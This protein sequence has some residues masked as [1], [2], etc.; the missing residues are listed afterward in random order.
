MA[1][2][3]V[4]VESPAKA[5]TIAGFLGRDYVV[6]ASIGHIR[7]LPTGAAEVPDAYKGEPWARIGVDVDNDFKPLYIIP[8]QKKEQVRKLKGLVKDASEVYLATDEDREGESIA[9]HLSEVLAPR[10][11]VKRMVFHEITRPAIDRA[12]REWRDLD[13]RLVDAQE[14][15]RI[16]DRLYGYEVSPVLWKKV[17]PSL[18]AGRVQSVATRLLVERERAR[19]RFRSASFWDVEGVFHKDGNAERF[20]ASLVSVDGR[21]LASGRDF[22]E[23]GRL[24]AGSAGVLVLDEA[25]ASGLADRLA[26][27]RFSVRSVE[28]KPYRRSPYPPFMTSTLQQEAGRKLRFSS[29]RTMRVAQ[30]LY[31]QGYITYM[32]TDSTTLSAEALA[33]ARSQ[34]RSLYG[35]AYVP[36]QPRRYDKKVKNAQEAHE[37][38]RPAGE[39]FRTPDQTGLKGDMFRLYDLVWKR[40]VAS[41]MADAR[42]HSI[43]VR[44]GARSSSGD[45]AEFATSG[46]TIEFPGFLRAYV[47][48][49]DDP[50]AALEDQEVRLPV[51]AVGDALDALAL[52]AKGHAT[53]PPAR[54]TEASL[55]KALE[56]LGVGR[57][58]T[59]ASIIE[60][61]Q[62][63]GYVDRR[64]TA[65][66]PSWT[67]FAVVGLLEQYFTQLVDYGFTAQMEEELDEIA[68]GQGEAIPW[69][70]RFYFGDAAQ[71]K[72][73]HPSQG[74]LKQMVNDQLGEIDAREVNSIPVGNGIVLRVGRYGPYIQR[75]DDRA[76]VPEDLAPDELTVA[77]AE[78]LLDAGS[79]DRPLGDDPDTGLPVVARA[80][81]FGPYVQLGG[82]DAANGGRGAKPK[83]Q[84]LLGGTTLD[85][86]TLD[87]ALR[88]LSLPRVVGA[89]VDGEEILAA[90]GRFG[91]YLKKGNDSRRLDSDDQLF[92]VTLD[93]ARALFA[94]PRPD[95]MAR[96]AAPLRELGPDPVSGQLVTVKE[97][98]FGPYV[99]DGITNASLRK[100]DTVDGVSLERAAELLEVRRQA[101]PK[102]ARGRSSASSR[103]ATPAA[104]KATAASKKEP[105]KAAPASKRAA[106][107]A[108]KASGRS[109]AGGASAKKAATSTAAVKKAATSTAA[110]KKAAPSTAATK[111]ARGA[112]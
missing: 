21:R 26:E 54:Y 74:G 99:T 58:S 42:G 12:V 94:Q 53:Q 107:G 34:A 1:K 38:I 15:R 36:E 83:T 111:K 101:A 71:V 8:R 63:R 86:V 67:A 78:E 37:A 24:V 52:D 66:V 27:A 108:K 57:P 91:P 40:T 55:V 10:V 64:G 96:A 109:Q 16:L 43:Q 25:G 51:L 61:I 105:R 106:S 95:R 103:K 72:T 90:H 41:Q 76:Q 14:A 65:L 82:L 97:G 59:Y 22:G 35:D 62:A 39:T 60:N 93:E 81:R 9:W 79:S 13:R 23:D 70:A 56:E 87:E 80:G 104:K 3:L 28:E 75:G 4:I 89:D 110:A 2:P 11:P 5:K 92:T 73:E 68:N 47:E 100:G 84:S 77:K 33:A 85:T 45:D 88:L 19:I 18:S 17:R 50:N 32:R 7:D 30:D 46:K 112:S 44:L 20:G 6:E 98:R 102:P 48:G 69:L 31:E 49:S 29:Q